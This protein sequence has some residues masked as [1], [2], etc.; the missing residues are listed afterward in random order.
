MLNSDSRGFLIADKPLRID[1]LADGIDGVR[2][3]T[4]AILAL[5]KSSR[6]TARLAEARVN[7]AGAR[8]MPSVPRE[9]DAQGRFV[10]SRPA[11]VRAELSP[12]VRAVDQLTRQQEK[13]IGED[14]RAAAARTNRAGSTTSTPVNQERDGRGRFSAGA[15]N[16]ERD[17]S[18]NRLFSR[19]RSWFK[20]RASFGS[21][22]DIDKVDPAIEATKEIGRLARTPASL[23][24][25]VGKATIGRGFNPNRGQDRAGSG[26]LIRIWTELRLGR[27]QTGIMEEA[28]TRV[29]KSINKK[30]GARQ[31]SGII[32]RA[33]GALASPFTKLNPL[34]RRGPRGYDGGRRIRPGRKSGGFAKKAGGLFRRVPLLG[35]LLAGG[36]ALMSL[37]GDDDPDLTPEENRANRFGGVGSGVGAGVGTVVGGA[38]GS[39]LGGPIGGPVGALIG[40]IIG[41]RVGE[42]A[43]KWLSTVDMSQLPKALTE[44]WDTFISYARSGWNT[45][46]KAISG[47]FGTVFASL[48]KGWD[49]VVQGTKS[50]LKERLGIDV[51]KIIG[52]VK[53]VASSAAESTMPVA[54]V[55]QEAVSKAAD[56]ASYA[57][58][59]IQ[60]GIGYLVGTLN[61]DYRHGAK[62]EG[63]AGAAGLSKY[64]SYTN[65]EIETINRL[66]KS[67]AN[68]SANLAGGMPA[69]IQRKIIAAA[70]AKGLNPR[71]MLNIAAMESGGN[72]NAVSSTGAIGI[73]QFVGRTATGVGIRDRFNVDQNIEG[74][75]EL[76]LQNKH[77]L[78]DLPATAEN[79][80]LMHQLGPV[81]KEVIR[82]ASEGKRID[83]LS[84]QA[85]KAISLNYGGNKAKTAAEYIAMNAKALEDRGAK[86]VGQSSTGYLPIPTLPATAAG[87]N[88]NVPIGSPAYS[89]S[90]A[91]A[92]E[93]ARANMT[94]LFTLP[95]R[96]TLPPI[97]EISIPVPLTSGSPLQVTL[98]SDQKV[99][100]DVSDRR[101]AN[102]ATGGVSGSL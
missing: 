55:A 12:V 24:A 31:G 37:F 78:G 7:S 48:G 19:V 50:F 99:G 15:V 10:P 67:G 91:I 42:A 6:R 100:Q 34:G 1:E 92:A 35:A 53:D 25:T 11:A 89:F 61:K 36:G 85:R 39:V 57:A 33:A 44:R 27:R 58:T 38:L 13:K 81:A 79:L 23:A 83:Q 64:G 72:A 76:A 54:R 60:S 68:T 62:F 45:V 49:T 22:G 20:D 59:T 98:I 52:T 43:G 51:D 2:S 73:Y 94:S 75:M 88:S 101:I 16:G 4:S 87:V 63:F 80:Y 21:S 71:D 95:S 40:G 70:I 47:G 8:R 69:D 14:R 65:D 18:E 77:A 84:A 29:L 28:Q 97:P 56:A 66:K 93:P 5:L 96:A 30:S 102:I 3:D 86:A 9:R 74:G 26:W 90:P 32:S 46:I 82:G 17:A 41:D